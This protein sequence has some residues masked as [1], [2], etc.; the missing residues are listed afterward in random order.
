MY[1]LASAAAEAKGVSRSTQVRAEA[2]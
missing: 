1:A 2:A